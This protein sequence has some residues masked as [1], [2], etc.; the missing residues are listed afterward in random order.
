MTNFFDKIRKLDAAVD[1]MA[2][3]GASLDS[4]KLMQLKIQICQL[5]NPREDV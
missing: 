4:W 2:G 5:S 3:K 1:L